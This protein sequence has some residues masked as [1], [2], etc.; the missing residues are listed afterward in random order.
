MNP[1]QAP[2]NESISDNVKDIAVYAIIL[3]MFRRGQFQKLELKK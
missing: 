2:Q 1:A 3:E